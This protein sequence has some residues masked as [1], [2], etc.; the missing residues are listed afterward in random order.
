LDEPCE[1]EQPCI[2]EHEQMHVD[3]LF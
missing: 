2:H 3:A 1:D